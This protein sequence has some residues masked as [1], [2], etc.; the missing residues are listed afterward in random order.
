MA[1]YATLLGLDNFVRQRGI[2]AEKANACLANAAESDKLVKMRDRANTE[3]NLEGTPTFL[4]NGQKQDSTGTW[5]Q[6]EAKLKAA[7]A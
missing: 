5:E 3:Y 1:K 2:S 7:G 6:L 4:I